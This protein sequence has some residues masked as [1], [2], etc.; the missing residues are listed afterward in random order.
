[1]QYIPKKKDN[2]L[3]STS[4]EVI[5]VENN[6]QSNLI[7]TLE[8]KKKNEEQEAERNQTHESAKISGNGNGAISNANDGVVVQHST[9][10]SM[11]LNNVQDNIVLGDIHIDD[12][13]YGVNS[14]SIL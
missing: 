9:S 11:T 12:P 5:E 2:A 1:M 3:P 6:Q 8:G 10:F 13:A 14:M 4:A 7:G